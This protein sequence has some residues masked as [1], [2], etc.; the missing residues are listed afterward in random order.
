MLIGRFYFRRTISGNLIG[1][2]SNQ[3]SITNSTESA[4]RVGVD[5]NDFSGNYKSTWQED[6]VA[7]VADLKIDRK[8]RA[9]DIFVLR[10]DIQG[11]N[12]FWGEAL[13]AEN[14]LIG[15]Y[16]DFNPIT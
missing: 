6:G 11:R 9:R 4:E 10:W 15:D 1:E 3:H 13:L 5:T 12:G 7:V 16:R 14:L 8:H 2:F